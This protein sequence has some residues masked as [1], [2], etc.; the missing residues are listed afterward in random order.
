MITVEPTTVEWVHEHFETDKQ[1]D[2]SIGVWRVMDGDTCVF[3]CGI[4]RPSLLGW[5]ELWLVMGTI[6]R[7]ALRMRRGLVDLL[8]AH[9]P[10][11]CAHARG[12]VN[13]R[14]AE[15]FGFQPAGPQIVDGE[16]WT[17][18]ELP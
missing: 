9:Y 1:I 3:V 4:L 14:F 12:R 8:R 18:F 11:T 16:T 6:T 5:C 7:R 17:R 13:E 10:T 2:P 15:F